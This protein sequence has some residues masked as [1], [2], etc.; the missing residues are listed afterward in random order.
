VPARLRISDLFANRAAQ[1]GWLSIFVA[2]GI[3]NRA[4]AE[5]ANSGVDRQSEQ[6]CVAAASAS[7]ASRVLVDPRKGSWS[8]EAGSRRA[9]SDAQVEVVLARPLSLPVGNRFVKFRLRQHGGDWDAY[10]GYLEFRTPGQPKPSYVDS[11]T[12]TTPRGKYVRAENMLWRTATEGGLI[13]PNAR[14]V[15]AEIVYETT[16]TQIR[17][18]YQVV[19]DDD[20]IEVCASADGKRWSPLVRKTGEGG[21]TPRYRDEDAV[22]MLGSETVRPGFVRCSAA[23]AQDALGPARRITAQGSLADG[24]QLT[25]EW[26]LLD[27]AP[28]VALD[29]AIANTSGQTAHLLQLRPGA[30]FRI[31]AGAPAE[32]CTV[33]GNDY[34]MPPRP[35]VR[36]D[37]QAE[38]T[39]WWSTAVIDRATERAV[40]LGIGEAA[41]AGVTVRVSRRGDEVRGTMEAGLSPTGAG[42]PLVLPPGK[43]FS[44]CRLLFLSADQVHAGLE[45]YATLMA[46]Q[47]RVELRHRPYTG[48]FTGY[49]SSPDLTTVVCLDEKRVAKLLGVVKEKVGRYGID[50]IKIEFEPCGSPNL[51]DPRQYQ[52]EKHFSQG[53]RALVESIRGLGFRPAIQSRTFLYVRGGDPK[54]REK[55]A[56]I[57]RRFT[58]EWGFEY[59][60]LDFNVTDIQNDDP[61]RPQIQVFRDRFRMIREAVGPGIFLEACMIPYGPVVGIADGF[62]PSID[63]R[64]GNE[65]ELLGNFAGRYFLHGR[66]F[67]LDSEFHDV[68][69]RPFVWTK[70]DVVTPVAGMRAWVSLC[71]LAG[72]SYLLGGAIEETS[73][74]RWAV[75]SRA[76]PVSGLGARPV[77]LAE[78][79]LPQIWSLALSGGPPRQQTT[80]LFNW[81]Y[82]ASKTIG[83]KLARC[84]LAG[85]KRYAAFD[86][87]QQKFLGEVSDKLETTLPARNGQVIWLTEITGRPEIIGASR[88]VT[89]LF[90]GKV[91]RWNPANSTLEGTVQGLGDS[92]VSLFVYVPPRWPARSATGA[93]FEQVEQRVVRVDVSTPDK[94][95]PWAITFDPAARVR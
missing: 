26:S 28:V 17:W 57:Y 25:V 78:R 92:R 42:T 30:N 71:A 72:Y 27:A 66:V 46:K 21:I 19:H 32:R 79:A 16:A 22:P 81:N 82:D 11:F 4:G 74:E 24:L 44:L 45:H 94:E 70:R 33:L 34:W 84:G 62:R 31:D 53:P 20:V 38:T 43:T 13:C 95:T 83:V 88:H 39:P 55:T 35:I 67:Q 69:M 6:T 29:L 54:E 91:T 23:P 18:V 40:V 59:L 80:G 51:L 89:G 12:A 49:S 36:L 73:D 1:F 76:L 75:V 48:L 9:I 47:A 77:D 58:R 41:N 5:T 3:V 64:G 68:A 90:R 61:T 56:E 2:L 37:E 85:D 15:W 50:F 87:W 65:D 8:F 86:F 52:M 93:A 60:M 14:D 63:F 7:S 10:L